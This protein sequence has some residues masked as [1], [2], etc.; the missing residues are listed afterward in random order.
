MNYGWVLYS[1]LG[2]FLIVPVLE[3]PSILS[4]GLS[5]LESPALQPGFSFFMVILPSAP[6]LEPFCCLPHTITLS[7]Y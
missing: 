4:D 1:E 2:Y 3:V 5:Y 6:I 7:L